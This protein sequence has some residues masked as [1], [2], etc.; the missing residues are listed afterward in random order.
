M[1]SGPVAPL[2]KVADVARLLFPRTS[3]RLARR[4]VY[5][6]VSSGTIPSHVILKDGRAI[7]LRRGL[8]EQWLHGQKNG[9]RREEKWP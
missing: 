8:L 4:Q 3:R 2:L 6:W 5:R 1:K 9:D 7:W